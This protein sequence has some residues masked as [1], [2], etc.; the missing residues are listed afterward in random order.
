MTFRKRTARG[1][2]LLQKGFPP[3]PLSENSHMV[4]E[5]R[6][7]NEKKGYPRACVN[8]LTIDTMSDTARLNRLCATATSLKRLGGSSLSPPAVPDSS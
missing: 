3:D 5:K 1:K 2:T 8:Y 6:E 7:S 4:A